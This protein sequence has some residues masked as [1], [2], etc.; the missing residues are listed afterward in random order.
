MYEL[1]SIDYDFH[2]V[3]LEAKAE[4]GSLCKL[5]VR[6]GTLG[7]F[8]ATLYTLQQGEKTSD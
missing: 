1:R 8:I 5:L 2:F 6:R 7:L 3:R 4:L